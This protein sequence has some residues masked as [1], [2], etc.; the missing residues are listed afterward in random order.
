[1][2]V[3]AYL[4]GTVLAEHLPDRLSAAG[5]EGRSPP[6]PSTANPTEPLRRRLP[7]VLALHGWGRDRSDLIPLLA[8]AGY[9]ALAVDL[10]G[11][12]SSPPPPGV[13]GAAEYA[14]AVS[15]LIAEVGGGPYLVLGHS[16]G[17]R[18]AACL[19]ADHPRHVAAVVLAGVPLWRPD[20]APRPALGFRVVRM[21][22]RLGLGRRRGLEAARRRYGSSDYRAAPATMRDVLVRVVNEDYRDRLGLIES[23]VALIWGEHDS[24]APA[25]IAVEAARIL[26]RAV[27]VDIVEGA[28]HDV[29]WQVPDR[30]VGAMEAVA[31]EVAGP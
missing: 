22:N 7:P 13:W 16:F 29:H 6:S 11:F 19:A 8:R 31:L 9:E 25:R 28:G 27:T 10:P 23:P 5:A 12:G 24:A 18:V 21:A 2:T 30:V 15:N 17:G 1:M 3:R 14:T 4:D 20:P 26:P